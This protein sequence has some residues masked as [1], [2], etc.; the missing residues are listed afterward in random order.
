MHQDSYRGAP[1]ISIGENRRSVGTAPFERAC[2]VALLSWKCL[3]LI[4]KK[5]GGRIETRGPA[6]AFERPRASRLSLERV[7][8]KSWTSISRGSASIIS[9]RQPGGSKLANARGDSSARLLPGRVGRS[10]VVRGA[11]AAPG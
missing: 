1:T 11:R 9:R 7:G 3:E 5:K 6:A 10:R 4:E 2:A 8:W